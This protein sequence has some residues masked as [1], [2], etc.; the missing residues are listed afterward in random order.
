MCVGAKLLT[1]L[2]VEVC[3]T[4]PADSSAVAGGKRN[5]VLYLKAHT[6]LLTGGYATWLLN[7]NCAGTDNTE[8]AYSI[9]NIAVY[10]DGLGKWVAVGIVCEFVGFVVFE[11]VFVDV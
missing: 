7:D 6:H 5:N 1:A 4:M 10:I 2:N 8:H 9:L 3:D 11:V